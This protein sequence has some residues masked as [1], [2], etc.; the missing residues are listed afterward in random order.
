[1]GAGVLKVEMPGTGDPLRALGPSQ[2]ETSLTWAAAAR[3][4]QSMTLN[5]KSAA[6]QEVLLRL[7]SEHDILV[8]NFRPGTLDRWG[9]DIDRIRAANPDIVVVR[10]TGYGQTGPNATKA[11]FGT[12]AT[13]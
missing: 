9:L 8:E 4:K 11:G 10:V 5:L 6:G 2:G 3:N 12:P 7:I 13:A 1:M